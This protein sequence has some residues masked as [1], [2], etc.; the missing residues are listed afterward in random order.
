LG[1]IF[2]VFLFFY[3]RFSGFGAQVSSITDRSG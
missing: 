1:H 3:F 2:V